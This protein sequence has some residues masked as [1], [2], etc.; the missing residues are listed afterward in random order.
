MCF[1]IR[2]CVKDWIFFAYMSC[3][4]F[5]VCVFRLCFSVYVV[6][7]IFNGGCVVFEE[8]DYG[9]E[10]HICCQ[11][12]AIWCQENQNFMI[13][14]YVSMTQIRGVL[15]IGGFSRIDFVSE[16]GILVSILG[17]GVGQDSESRG[18]G[19]ETIDRYLKEKNNQYFES[20]ILF[21][22]YQKLLEDSRAKANQV[23]VCE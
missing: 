7:L 6:F 13:D 18:Q 14:W 21:M 15:V 8:L 23:Y 9:L 1:C 12:L 19:M 20:R 22:T 3:F 16:I 2:V 10:L 11:L 5:W 17:R 4:C